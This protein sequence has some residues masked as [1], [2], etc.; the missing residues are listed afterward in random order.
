[1]HPQAMVDRA[2]QL[3]QQGL[4]DREVALIIGVPLEYR[5]EMAYWRP[6]RSWHGT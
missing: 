1:M 3:S 4:I 2:R 5:P 6:A